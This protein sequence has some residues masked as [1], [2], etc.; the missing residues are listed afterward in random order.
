MSDAFASAGDLRADLLV[1][2]TA[3]GSAIALTLLTRVLL[4]LP[5][6]PLLRLSPLAVYPLYLL[7]GRGDT[8]SVIED[9]RLWA[10]AAVLAALVA[11]ASVAI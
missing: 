2:G 1:A 11:F 10:G 7:L 8:G 6:G 5:A 9:P 3:A 4:D